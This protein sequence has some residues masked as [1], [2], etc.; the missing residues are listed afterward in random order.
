MKSEKTGMPVLVAV[1][2]SKY[3]RWSVRWA[4]RLPLARPSHVTALHVVDLSPLAG[5]DVPPLMEAYTAQLEEHARAIAEEID[6]LRSSLG[7]D[8]RAV[9][10]HGQV[11]NTIVREAKRGYG[12]VVIGHR[13]T[14]GLARFVIGSV[15]LHVVQSAPCPVLV[16]KQSP[17]AVSRILVAVDGSKAS[18]RVV[19]FLTT[20]LR[21]TADPSGAQAAQSAVEAVVHHVLP[22]IFKKD[23]AEIAG[24]AV[25]Q[26]YAHKLAKAGYRIMEEVTFGG[27]AEE[28]TAMAKRREVQLVVAGAK[29]RGN[30]A[31]FLLGSVA[32]R[33]VERSHVSVL[34]V[35]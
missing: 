8:G 23:E 24:R 16:V 11:A 26:R 5:L 34:V 17:S 1:D 25:V 19:Q 3:G 22:F 12:L 35:R 27:P 6:T 10:K 14:T 30:V 7:L 18:D 32:T 31:A 29:G 21:P 28:L 9:V 2:G 20:E 33:L 15:A 4:A 13:G